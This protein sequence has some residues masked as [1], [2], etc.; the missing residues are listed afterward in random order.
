MVMARAVEAYL[1]KNLQKCESETVRK[2]ANA[3][4]KRKSHRSGWKN[5]TGGFRKDSSRDVRK[6]F[7]LACDT[8]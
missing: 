2:P 1:N 4:A 6:G 7:N 3:R 8:E 5:T